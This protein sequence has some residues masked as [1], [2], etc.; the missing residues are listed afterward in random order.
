MKKFLLLMLCCFAMQIIS[1]SMGIIEAEPGAT[2][3]LIKNDS[4]IALE[5]VAWNKVDF[6][7]IELGDVSEKVVSAGQGYVYFSCKN[8]QYA[9]YDYISVEKHKREEF[10]IHSNTFITPINSQKRLRLE[11]IEAE[12]NAD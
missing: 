12:Q 7:N 2:K 4:K 10:Y 11:E 6:G 5:N 3:F 8:K 9:T 1:C